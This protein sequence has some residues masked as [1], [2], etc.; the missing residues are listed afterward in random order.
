MGSLR[1]TVWSRARH[2][3]EYCQ[4]PQASSVLPLELDHIRARK[5]RGK[6]TAQNLCLACA[7]CNAAKGTNVVGYDPETDDLVAL[8]DPRRDEWG[9]HFAWNGPVLIGKTP[10][11]RATIEV[12]GINRPDRIQHRRLLHQA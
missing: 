3:C 11:G 4:L 6:S 5:H 12:L 1:E 8:F 7:Y 9:E 2:R 10:K